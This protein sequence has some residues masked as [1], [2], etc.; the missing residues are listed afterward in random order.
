MNLIVG[1][2]R[3]LALPDPLAGNVKVLHSLAE[4]NGLF[5]IPVGLGLVAFVVRELSGKA[6]IVHVRGVQSVHFVNIT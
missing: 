1:S 6:E 2:I 3:Q 4:F 5:P